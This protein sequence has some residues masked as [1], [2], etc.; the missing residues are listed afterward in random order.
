[1]KKGRPCRFCPFSFPETA[2]AKGVRARM[3]RIFNRQLPVVLALFV[4]GLFANVQ[5]VISLESRNFL[6]KVR[7]KTNTIYLLGSVHLFKKEMYPLNRKIE[8]AFNQSDLLAVEANLNALHQ[9]DLQKLIEKAIYLD[10]GD[11]LERHVSKGTHDLIK[12]KAEELGIP[13][14]LINRQKPWFLGLMFT[15]A[16]FLRLGFDPNY[17]IDQYFL[18]KAAGK[19]TIVE[20]ESLD[21][22]I[23]LLSSFNDHDQE[24]FLLMALR[25]LD[26]LGQDVDQFLQSWTSGDA[27][28]LEK[29]ATRSMTEDGRLSSIYETLIYDR[30]R[31]MVSKIEDFLKTKETYFVIVGAGH[32]VGGKGIVEILKAKGYMVEQL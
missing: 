1:M 32:L 28:S 3:A 14:E 19:K 13:L 30:N 31:K 7:S 16:G 8:E 24:L 22:Q 12:K 27:K 11:A 26:T 20:L 29:M 17:G 15:S 2:R 23:D 4:L 6:W 21:Y 18:S 25:D 10:D 9:L 5:N